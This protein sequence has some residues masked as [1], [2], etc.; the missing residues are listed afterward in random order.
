MQS[1]AQMVC[2]SS[3]LF[4]FFLWL[5][6]SSCQTWHLHPPHTPH[7]HTT[8]TPPHCKEH[9]KCYGCT[10]IQLISHQVHLNPPTSPNLWSIF[11]GAVWILSLDARRCLY[12]LCRRATH[13]P[14]DI[15]TLWR[16]QWQES[17]VLSETGQAISIL[18]D[19]Q[20]VYDG[21]CCLSYIKM[22]PCLS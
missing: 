17:V 3:P 22:V 8:I 16:R 9:H 7:I 20:W 19:R 12:T 10:P 1:W 18:W 21:S 11:Q 15:H 5:L 13:Q 6:L 14:A 2:L 4:F